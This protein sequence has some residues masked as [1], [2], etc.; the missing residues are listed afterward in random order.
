[1][2]YRIARAA[3]LAFVDR[4]I[5]LVESTPPP[6]ELELAVDGR[7]RAP[8]EAQAVW[9]GAGLATQIGLALLDEP[10]RFVVDSEEAAR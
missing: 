1:M 4:Q 7:A 2:A 6:A 5:S 9:L 10:E 8:D 3:L